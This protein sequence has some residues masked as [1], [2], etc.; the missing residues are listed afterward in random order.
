MEDKAPFYPGCHTFEAEHLATMASA[1]VIPWQTLE[2]LA[3][4]ILVLF[5]LSIAFLL[6]KLFN[7]RRYFRRLQKQGLVSYPNLGVLNTRC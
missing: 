3:R 7:V 2:L 4:S 5:F 6:V 1:A